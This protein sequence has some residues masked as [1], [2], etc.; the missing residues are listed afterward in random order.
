VGMKIYKNNSGRAIGIKISN[1]S[2]KMLR[3]S[4]LKG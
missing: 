4:E 2:I 3:K 1:N